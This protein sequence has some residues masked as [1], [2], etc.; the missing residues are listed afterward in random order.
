MVGARRRLRLLEYAA[1]VDL[2]GE[3][4]RL[5]GIDRPRAKQ[6]IQAA[7]ER[8]ARVLGMNVSPLVAE[9]GGVRAMDVA[10][11]IRLAPALELEIAPKFL[12]LDADDRHWREDFYFLANLSRHGT[13]LGSERLRASGGAPRDLATLVAR[14][15]IGMYWD[16]RRNPLRSYRRLKEEDVF[17]DGDIDPFDIRFPGPDG[18]VQ[19]MIRYDRR[20][21]H[22]AAIVAA[23]KELLPEVSDAEA[24]A[25]LVH[26]VEDLPGQGRPDKFR[27]VRKLPGRSRRWQP[28]VDLA[29]DVVKGLGLSF[30]EGFAS[31]PGYIVSTWRTWEDLLV[32][33]MRLAY[34]RDVVRS[35]KAHALGTR[36][37][38]PGGAASLLNV[39]PDLM[40]ATVNQ[41]PFVMD[42]K[43]KTSSEKGKVRVSEADAYEALAFARATKCETVILAYPALP[44]AEQRPLGDT[45]FFERLDV[46]GT[47]IYAA[48]VEVRG[49]SRRSGLKSFS[50]RLRVG[51]EKALHFPKAQMA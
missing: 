47:R 20:N 34:G 39:Y 31:A 32:V 16:N 51:I 11:M 41:P 30:E 19:E 22:N 23:A 7:G 15:L 49:V 26:L 13:L 33:G 5:A 14:S 10:G 27:R 3:A 2:A 50:D 1:P 37:K 8:V 44:S 38:L 6:L 35:H 12:G 43:Y 48:Q 36:A 18:F 4:S 25:G 46:A 17:V 9:A 24:I 21:S 28:V 45:V 42:A 29:N 40:V